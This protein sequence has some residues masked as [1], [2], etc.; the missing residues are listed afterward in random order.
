MSDAA[1]MAIA[2]QGAAPLTRRQ[3]IAL[4]VLA[5]Q[6]YE[7]MRKIGLAEEPFDEW[8]RAAVAEAV[9]GA[10][11]LRDL[12]QESFAAAAD[13]FRALR[14]DGRMGDGR[15]LAEEDRRRRAFWAL[16]RCLKR[17]E[18]RWPGPGTPEDYARALF[19]RIHGTTMEEATARQIWLVTITFRNRTWGSAPRRLPGRPRKRAPGASPRPDGQFAAAAAPR[20]FP[21]V[22]RAGIGHSGRGGRSEGRKG[23]GNG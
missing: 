18:E 20:V 14:D 2:G 9:P 3:T 19:E 15:L 4:A 17:A 11:G 6:A 12:S 10:K 7:R 8:R 1:D 22:S 13:Y 21:R 5:R 16:R 23:D